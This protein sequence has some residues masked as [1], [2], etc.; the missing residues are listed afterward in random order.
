MYLTNLP[1]SKTASNPNSEQDVS[2]YPETVMLSNAIK[3]NNEQRILQVLNQIINSD[4]QSYNNPV[5]SDWI[6]SVAFHKRADAK[7]RLGSSIE[8]IIADRVNAAD[9]GDVDQAIYLAHNLFPKDGHSELGGLKVDG[10]ARFVRFA[11]ELGDGYSQSII[12]S[13]ELMTVD[14]KIYWMLMSVMN[15]ASDKATKALVLSGILSALGVDAVRS[16]LN[17]FSPVGGMMHKNDLGLPSRGYLTTITLASVYETALRPRTPI[18]DRERAEREKPRSAEELEKQFNEGFAAAG[19]TM[20]SYLLTEYAVKSDSQ[21]IITTPMK[22]ILRE[23]RPGDLVIVRCGPLVHMAELQR[24]DD[25]EGEVYLHDDLFSFWEPIHNS[26]VSDFSLVRFLPG[27]YAARVRTEELLPMI[28]AV[29]VVRDRP[30][31]LEPD[32]SLGSQR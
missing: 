8:E 26:C 4:L 10:A 6:K 15:S 9:L 21:F 12:S 27:R 20:R 32:A 23:L 18:F 24:V 11:A 13:L 3:D 19:L 28:E 5:Y 30:T 31:A 22:Q 17:R 1:S 29:L 14:E 25:K 2:S 16:A 7:E